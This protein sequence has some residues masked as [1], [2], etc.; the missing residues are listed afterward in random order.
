VVVVVVVVVTGVW[1][2][3]RIHTLRPDRLRHTKTS[4]FFLEVLFIL[5]VAVI[6]LPSF[7]FAHDCPIEIA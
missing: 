6:R 2:A 4:F 3:A 1:M 5:T 7:A